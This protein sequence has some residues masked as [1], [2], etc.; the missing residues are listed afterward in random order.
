M[1][2]TGETNPAR[3]LANQRVTGELANAYLDQLADL[4]KGAAR[5]TVKTLSNFL[6]LAEI[7]TLFPG[8]RIIHCR[9]N[10]FDLCLSCYFQNFKD[11]AFAWSLEDI[12]ICYRAYE[13]LM[14]HWSGVLPLPIHE[15]I[16]EE[17]VDNQEPI[18][19]K[20]LNFCG[21]DWDERCMAFFKTRRVVRTAS[22][23]QVRKPISRQAVGRWQHFRSHLGPLFA[24]LA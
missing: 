6:H 11:M 8:A 19:R 14:A 13:K 17:L 5:V 22:T 4:G 10:P 2:R 18:T 1:S 16:Y 20:L 7:A 15:V 12:G 24:A 3:L 23:I 9:R 21:L